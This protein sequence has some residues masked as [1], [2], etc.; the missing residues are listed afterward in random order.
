MDLLSCQVLYH[1]SVSI[2][3]FEISILH[4]KLCD[5]LLSSHQFFPLETQLYQCVFLQLALVRSFGKLVLILCLSDVTFPRGPETD[6]REE[7]AGAFLKFHSVGTALLRNFDLNFSERRTFVFSDVCM[8]LRN[9]CES[10]S[11]N[12]SQNFCA[13]P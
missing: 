11:S 10:Y 4:Q 13:L 2:I 6:S 1:D 12:W 7:L 3:F 5:L 9:F 8:T